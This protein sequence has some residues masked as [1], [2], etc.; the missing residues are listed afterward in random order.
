MVSG[1]NDRWVMHGVEGD[2]S[3]YQSPELAHLEEFVQ[4]QPG[5][6]VLSTDPSVIVYNALL[7]EEGNRPTG[8]QHMADLAAA[9]PGTFDGRLT[10]YDAARNA[11][12]LAEWWFTLEEM[13]DEGWEALAA[14]G[15][16]M[17]METSAGPMI[18]KIATG[19]YV[20]GIG[21]GGVTVFPRLEEEGAGI[22]EYAFPDDGTPVMFRGMGIPDNATSPN[23]AQLMLDYLL[24]HAG[25]TRIGNAGLTPHREDVAEDEVLYTYQEVVDLV[26]EENVIPVGFSEEMVKDA[27]AFAE[28]WSEVTAPN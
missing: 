15:P 22:M 9:D 19:E 26:G 2:M 16:M 1:A 6:Y 21:L 17:R 20:A 28:R 5:V 23:S 7:L 27:Q 8:L 25:Q 24:S 4:P 10:T 14:V 13:G 3:D 11:F 12:G 18:E